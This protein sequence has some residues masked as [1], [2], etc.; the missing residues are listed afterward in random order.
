MVDFIVVL[1]GGERDLGGGDADYWT[2]DSLI[3]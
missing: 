3:V 2:C 1:R